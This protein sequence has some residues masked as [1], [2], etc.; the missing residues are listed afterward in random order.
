MNPRLRSFFIRISIAGMLAWILATGVLPRIP[1][2]L[3]VADVFIPIII[4]LLFCYIGK[5]II[6]TFFYNHYNP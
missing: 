2:H 1:I 3:W 6:D 4:F 5:L